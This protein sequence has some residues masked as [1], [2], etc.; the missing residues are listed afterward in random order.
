MELNE[1]QKVVHDNEQLS[2][3]ET[4]ALPDSIAT[5]LSPLTAVMTTTATTSQV[6]PDDVFNDQAVVEPRASVATIHDPIPSTSTSTTNSF[7]ISTIT[8]TLDI[9]F[10]DLSYSV[11]TGLLRRGK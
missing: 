10:E 9:K 6:A 1:L 11:K 3:A 5:E 7:T 2:G 4:D 8:R